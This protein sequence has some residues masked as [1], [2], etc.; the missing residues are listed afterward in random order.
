MLHVISTRELLLI[1]VAL[2]GRKSA[3]SRLS[4]GPRPLNGSLWITPL[5]LSGLPTLANR[6]CYG[7]HSRVD[8]FLHQRVLTPL[9]MDSTAENCWQKDPCWSLW[10]HVSTTIECLLGPHTSTQTHSRKTAMLFVIFDQLKKI[11]SRA[12]TCSHMLIW[13]DSIWRVTF[14][15]NIT[16]FLKCQLMDWDRNTTW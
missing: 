6:S 10:T 11:L 5:H 7:Y 16:Y 12:V 15:W 9:M 13:Y 1:L 4:R 3:V 8:G 14:G 2:L